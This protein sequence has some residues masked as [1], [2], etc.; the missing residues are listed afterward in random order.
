MLQVR[1]VEKL[2]LIRQDQHVLQ[3]KLFFSLFFFIITGNFPFGGKLRSPPMLFYIFDSDENQICI[4]ESAH[5]LYST[6]LTKYSCRCINNTQ[7]N[8]LKCSHW[9]IPWYNQYHL[10]LSLIIEHIKV[11]KS[12][13]SPSNFQGHLKDESL[14]LWGNVCK[15]WNAG[16][17]KVSRK[18]PLLTFNLHNE[19]FCQVLDKSFS[20]ARGVLNSSVCWG[21]VQ[22]PLPPSCASPFCSWTCRHMDVRCES[23]LEM[24][25]TLY[26]PG[27]KFLHTTI[28]NVNMYYYISKVK[29]DLQK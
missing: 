12:N 15:L 27:C 16:K 24:P 3:F 4:L 29:S 8:I 2:H 10:I 22:P 17:W 11:L 19:T 25:P 18:W 28:F 21:D 6:I 9:C 1:S 14:K 7:Y 26:L 20:S 23:Y 5:Y 13:N